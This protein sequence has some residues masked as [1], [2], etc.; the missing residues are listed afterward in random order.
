MRFNRIIPYSGQTR[1]RTIFLWYPRTEFI[2]ATST[3][4]TRWLERATIMEQYYSFFERWD[5]M[6][7]MDNHPI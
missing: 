7:F 5:F 3:R 1:T 4:D 6:L 2:Q